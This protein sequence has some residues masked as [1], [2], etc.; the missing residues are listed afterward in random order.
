MRKWITAISILGMLSYAI[1]A[2]AESRLLR[3]SLVGAGNAI[4]AA[5]TEIALRRP[6][7]EETNPLLGDRAVQRIA[8]KTALSIG[9]GVLL[10]QVAKK[11]PKV[12]KVLN[13]VGVSAY[14]AIA[15]HNLRQGR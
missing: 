8:I 5:S 1:P 4:D 11:H 7:T 6:N 12:A 9:Q 14:T 10:G 2:G 15:L 3:W 13:F